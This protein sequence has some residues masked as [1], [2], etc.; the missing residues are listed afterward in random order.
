M[1]WKLRGVRRGRGWIWIGRVLCEARNCDW[2]NY[3][4]KK[5][6]CYREKKPGSPSGRV[7][8]EPILAD[9]YL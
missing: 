4:D 8:A 5:L 1:D 6:A 7:A 9:V 3:E 2:Q